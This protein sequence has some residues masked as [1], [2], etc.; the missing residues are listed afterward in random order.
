MSINVKCNTILESA[1]D[2][3]GRI[4]LKSLCDISMALLGKGN[5]SLTP[6]P[7]VTSWFRIA[8]GH[9]STIYKARI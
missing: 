1:Q 3:S 9:I 5:S 6:A 4:M 7:L 2:G 8:V